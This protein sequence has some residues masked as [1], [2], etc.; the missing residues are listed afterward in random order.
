MVVMAEEMGNRYL[1][2]IE[3]KISGIFH[4]VKITKMNSRI[5]SRFLV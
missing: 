2:G 5:T 4:E 3:G 1:Q